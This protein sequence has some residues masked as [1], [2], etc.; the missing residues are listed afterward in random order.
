MAP[1]LLAPLVA[2]VVAAFA[3]ALVAL[4]ALCCPLVGIHPATRSGCPQGR[5]QPGTVVRVPA[6]S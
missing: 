6:H 1:R 3:V 4:A 2:V 5:C